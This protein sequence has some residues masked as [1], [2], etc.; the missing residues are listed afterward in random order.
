MAVQQ[1]LHSKN[2]FF[3]FYFIFSKGFL[4]KRVCL[5]LCSGVWLIF[6]WLCFSWAALPVTNSPVRAMARHRLHFP[7][8]WQRFFHFVRYWLSCEIAQQSPL[9]GSQLSCLHV[10]TL[11]STLSSA[12]VTPQGSPPPKWGK[13]WCYSALGVLQ[14][15]MPQSSHYMLFSVK[16]KDTAQ[17][18]LNKGERI[19]FSYQWKVAL[20][21][22]F[23]RNLHGFA[24]T[25][26][27]K[28]MKC[29]VESRVT[30]APC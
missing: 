21:R 7:C 6:F 23:L 26:G 12:G 30:T 20:P 1:Y 18:F 8:T 13:Y 11:R 29:V 9:W 3:L 17:S 25:A 10:V 16:I 24:L 15:K 14:L 4:L 27:R 28:G 19:L 22:E 5:L 2:G